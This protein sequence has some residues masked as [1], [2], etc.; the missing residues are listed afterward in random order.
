MTK[1]QEK[2][3]SSETAHSSRVLPS[4]METSSPLTPTQAAGGLNALR[5]EV[6][7]WAK[8]KGWWE[9]PADFNV[10]SKLMLTVS[11]LAEALEEF[12]SGKMDLYY[13]Y[14]A[15]DE[16]P[17]GLQI[18]NSVEGV[19]E[20]RFGDGPWNEIQ[21]HRDWIRLGYSAKPEGFGIELMD[22]FIRM[23]DLAGYMGLDLDQL[24]AIKMAYNTTRPHRHGGRAV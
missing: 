2:A 6:H 16:T 22:A 15:G 12:R 5:D 11:E 8:G 13:H 18:R 23:F 3:P 14:T 21:D 17:P 4:E 1:K 9:N 20:F 10:P 7:E 24:F 19:T